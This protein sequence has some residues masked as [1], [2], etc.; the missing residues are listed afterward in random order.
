M[1]NFAH[2]PIEDKAS[3]V[4]EVITRELNAQVG[5]TTRNLRE[6]LKAANVEGC[7]LP[8]LADLFH[9]FAAAL[10]RCH[11]NHRKPAPATKESHTVKVPLRPKILSTHV[12]VATFRA[13]ACPCNSNSSASRKT[14][15]PNTRLLVLIV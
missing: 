14:K 2:L 6:Q 13:I 4:D 12:I 11:L 1:Y 10:A 5:S 8:E 15:L 3:V 7:S 9:G